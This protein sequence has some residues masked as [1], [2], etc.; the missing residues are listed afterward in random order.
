LM[1]QLISGSKKSM[2]I[3]CAAVKPTRQQHIVGL[4]RCHK[5]GQHRAGSAGKIKSRW[6][7]VALATPSAT[8]HK[9]KV[10][11]A[12]TSFNTAITGLVRPQ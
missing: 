2:I 9:T 10:T 11:P 5:L 1:H 7:V 8:A 12:A 4:V 6:A 3:A